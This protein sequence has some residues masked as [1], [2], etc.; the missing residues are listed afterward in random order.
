M[1]PLKNGSTS[2]GRKNDLRIDG[3]RKGTGRPILA[4][5]IEGGSQRAAKAALFGLA[6]DGTKVRFRSSN[7]SDIYGFRIIVDTTRRLLRGRSAS[8]I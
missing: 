2:V 1:R 8:C 4:A 7:L 5:D 6:E 3:D